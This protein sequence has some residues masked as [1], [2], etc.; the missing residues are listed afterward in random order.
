M[1]AKLSVAELQQLLKASYDTN[2]VNVGDK[3]II[4]KSLSGP[5]VKVFT[6]AG[7]KD[8]IVTHRG[9]QNVYDWLDN[10]NYAAGRDIS[11]SGT[12]R[13][14]KSKHDA[15]VN[16][17]GKENI[18]SVGHSRGGAIATALHRKGL[19]AASIN[20]N[21]PT[22]FMDMLTHH[23]HEKTQTNIKS[24]ADPVST[25][26]PANKT[27]IVIPSKTLNPI[28]EHK[29]DVLD[30]LNQDML[31]GAGKKKVDFAKL[32]VQQLKDYVKKNKA[33]FPK[34]T[35]VTGLTKGQLVVLIQSN[36]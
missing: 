5:R 19:S 7:S 4:D 30:G 27:D 11:T 15:A 22:N 1:P 24:S 3:F 20:L 33:K 13:T 9:S 21:M 35:N 29:T 6:V 14:H 8:V 23:L 17:Y 34:G 31:I 26:M 10:V 16:K 18:T 32:K 25:L 2:L 36:L 28:T 12:Y